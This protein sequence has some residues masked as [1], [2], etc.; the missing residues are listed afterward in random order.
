HPK[1]TRTIFPNKP[2]SKVWEQDFTQSLKTNQYHRGYPDTS[3]EV[4]TLQRKPE[5]GLVG[6]DLLAK[7]QSGSQVT[8]GGVEFKGQKK[9]RTALMAR[10]VRVKRGDLLDRTKVEEG[11]YRLAQ[12]GA[13]ATVDLDYQLVD[14]H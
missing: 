3:V 4:Q 11:R 2:Y 14:E 8:M 5:D 13:F 12:L 9:T 7:I 6:L 10:R 1:E